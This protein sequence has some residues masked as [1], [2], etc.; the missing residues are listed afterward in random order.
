MPAAKF[1]ITIDQ[2]SDFELSVQVYEDDA[3]KDLSDYGARSQLRQKVDAANKVDFVT[4]GSAFDT[5]GTVKIEMNNITT[6][7]I[8]AGSYVYD[9]EIN[10]KF[11]WLANFLIADLADIAIWANNIGFGIAGTATIPSEQEYLLDFAEDGVINMT[12][13]IALGQWVAANRSPQEHNTWVALFA[14]GNYTSPSNI[15]SR[16]AQGN[17]TQEVTRILQ[18]KATVTGEVTR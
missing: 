7:G 8:T 15:I 4:T 11:S 3:V 13:S 12:D 6:S 16:I 1:D 5:T 9:I 2:G 14:A 17:Y 18:G 10:N